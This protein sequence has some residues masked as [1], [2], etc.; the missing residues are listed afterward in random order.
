M[1]QLRTVT[2][3]DF[4][5]ILALNEAQVQQTSP[6]DLARLRLLVG[7][8]VYCKVVIVQERV[9]AFLIALR[10]GVPYENDNYNWFT[11]RFPRFLYVDRIVVDAQFAGLRIGSKLYE[12]LFAF[13]RT[14]GIGRIVCEYNV[15]P[16][17]PASRRFHDKFGFK[18][19]GSQWVAN[20]TK[21]VSLQVAET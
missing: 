5:A 3:S 18:E 11:T 6:M 1:E 4:K 21:Q 10:E 8:S 16:P 14:E 13:A 17:N 20:G 15:D 7:M 12:N 2:E 9:A 19:L